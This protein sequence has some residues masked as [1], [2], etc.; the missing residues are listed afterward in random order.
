MGVPR[1]GV[2]LEPQLPADARAIATPDLSRV[3]DLQHSS[4]QRRILN[5]LSK[6]RNRTCNLTV[7]SWDSS[8]LRLAGTSCTTSSSIHVLIDVQVAFMSWLLRLVLLLSFI[9][10][11]YGFLQTDA[12]EWARR[13]TL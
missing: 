3:F 7:P 12:Q 9:I 6:A 13:I 10:S 4:W 8:P 11:N 2:E 1:L 5:P